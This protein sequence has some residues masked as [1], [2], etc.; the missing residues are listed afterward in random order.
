MQFQA[1]LTIQKLLEVVDKE[2]S[3]GRPL[4]SLQGVE[5][6]LDFRGDATVDGNAWIMR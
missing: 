4:R 6:L 2:L 1:R 3:Q 5:Q